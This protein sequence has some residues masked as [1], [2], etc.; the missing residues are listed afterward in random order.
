M[1]E[2]YVLIQKE[3]NVYTLSA[4]FL[5][6]CYSQRIDTNL[7]KAFNVE[8]PGIQDLLFRP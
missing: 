2:I 4:K 1:K 5:Q 7:H 3:T 6:N 8:K